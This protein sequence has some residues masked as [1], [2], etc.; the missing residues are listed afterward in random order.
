[1]LEQNKKLQQALQGMLNS[2]LSE[3][4]GKSLDKDVC[5]QIYVSL[6]TTVNELVYAVKPLRNGLDEK[7]VNF[8]AQAYYDMIEVNG[9]TLDPSVFTTR[10]FAKDLDNKQ[11]ALAA[12][13]L[14]GTPVMAEILSVIKKRS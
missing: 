5:V 9:Q 13:L 12:L 6:F 4:K 10:V 2:A 3:F 7:C 1:M 8:I 11:L 14:T